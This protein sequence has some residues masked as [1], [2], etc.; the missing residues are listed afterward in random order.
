M[1]V[2]SFGELVALERAR[3]DLTREELAERVGLVGGA[4]VEAFENGTA[5]PTGKVLMRIIHEFGCDEVEFAPLLEEIRRRE[6]ISE[7]ESWL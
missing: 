1:N 3:F 7:W 6:L 4:V 2:E 5:L